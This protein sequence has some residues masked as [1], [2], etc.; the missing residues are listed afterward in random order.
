MVAS[1][2]SPLTIQGFSQIRS[3]L[4]KRFFNTKPHCPAVSIASLRI[5]V[6][7][8]SSKEIGNNKMELDKL[9]EGLT[10]K[11]CNVPHLTP[12]AVKDLEAS[13]TP[14]LLIDTRSKEEQDV[15]T[16]PGS[17]TIEQF[18]SR[19]RDL[20]KDAKIVA[21]CTIGYR[22]SQYAGELRKRGLDA[23]NLEGSILAWTHESLPLVTKDKLTGQEVPTKTVH[24][25]GDQWRLQGE[26]YEP[27]VFKYGMLSYAKSAITSKISNLFK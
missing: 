7:M 4:P 27:V 12:R 17:L 8:S 16:I 22:S 2:T 6:A 19:E 26:G 14:I 21:Y 18:E 3:Q 1:L 15:S 10:T 23:S 20:P 13:G 5:T 24:V 9:V 25:F 11:F